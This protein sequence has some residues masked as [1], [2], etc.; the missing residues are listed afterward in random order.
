MVGPIPAESRF[1]FNTGESV[2]CAE[3]TQTPCEAGEDPSVRRVGGTT[4]RGFFPQ[5]LFAAYQLISISR[6]VRSS[7]PSSSSILPQTSTQF[8]GKT[9]KSPQISPL[10]TAQ[11]LHLAIHSNHTSILPNP[12]AFIKILEYDFRIP[13]SQR[14]VRP[15]SIAIPTPSRSPGVPLSRQAHFRYSA[16]PSPTSSLSV[17]SPPHNPP[18]PNSGQNP[19]SSSSSSAAPV[20]LISGI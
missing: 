16:S 2:R 15:C 4:K 14:E 20:T 19:A 8:P 7:I 18:L 9:D 13:L 17:P 1:Q 5:Y 12:L 6:Y 10:K 3:S 11:P